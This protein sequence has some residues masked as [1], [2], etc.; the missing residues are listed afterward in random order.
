MGNFD[1]PGLLITKD[2]GNKY[3]RTYEPLKN[4]NTDEL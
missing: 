1:Q 3:L 4:K 2:N